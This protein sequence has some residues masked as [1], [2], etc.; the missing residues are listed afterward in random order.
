MENKRGEREGRTV[1]QKKRGERR[2]SMKA[3]VGR[4]E[5]EGERREEN[6]RK[7]GKKQKG[8]RRGRKK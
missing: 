5:R 6:E 7:R 8:Q 2:K 3:S 1:I 4:E